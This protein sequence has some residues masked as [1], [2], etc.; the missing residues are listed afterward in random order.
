[1]WVYIQIF[2]FYKDTDHIELR[3]YTYNLTLTI[4]STTLF[5]HKVIYCGARG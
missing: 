4:S 2:P 5:P 1:M 3:A